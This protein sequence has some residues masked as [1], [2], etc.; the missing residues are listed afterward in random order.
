MIRR[1]STCLLLLLGATAHAAPFGPG[2]AE[3]EHGYFCAMETVAT[4]SASGTVSG[5]VNIVEG[6]PEFIGPGPEIPGRLGIGFG[7]KVRPQQRLAGP[8]TVEVVHPPMGSGAVTRQYWDTV[9]DGTGTQYLGY[10]FEQRYEVL[11]GQW[12]MSASSNGR[13][14]YSVSF[15]VVDP[16]QMPWVECGMQIPLS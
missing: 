10:T 14:I 15:T 9:L 3:L 12:T 2:A 7:V 16:R 11:P 4:Q 8:V 6:A 13:P 1:L 5:T